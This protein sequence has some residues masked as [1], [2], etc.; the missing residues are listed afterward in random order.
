MIKPAQPDDLKTLNQLA[1]ES[2]AYWGH[3]KTIM[4]RFCSMYQLTEQDL[5]EN[6]V[7]KFTCR[8]GNEITAFFNIKPEG[9]TAQLHHFYVRR[10]LIGRGLGRKLWKELIA[11][12]QEKG[13][14]VIEGVTFPK[15]LPFY[16][17]MGAVQTELYK[18]RLNPTQLIPKFEFDLSK[19][20]Y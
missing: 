12:C 8:A 7:R 10:D 14:Q 19:L 1:Y 15:A 5:E 13:F 9:E 3:S 16:L 17:K 6:I 11:L 2:E 20:I 18:S 4:S